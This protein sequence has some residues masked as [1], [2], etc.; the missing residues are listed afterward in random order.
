LI[1]AVIVN[2]LILLM[3]YYFGAPPTGREHC[4]KLVAGQLEGLECCSVAEYRQY[5]RWLWS[6]EYAAEPIFSGNS[7]A[8]G[9]TGSCFRHVCIGVIIVGA[10]AVV[11]TTGDG[12]DLQRPGLEYV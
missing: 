5:T 6:L 11:E 2:L 12:L 7:H 9:A 10:N 4:A 3:N 8:L 1:K